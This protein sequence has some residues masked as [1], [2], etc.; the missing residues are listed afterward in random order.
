MRKDYE[1]TLQV[2]RIDGLLPADDDGKVNLVPVG[3][4][5]AS[6][7]VLVPAW[8]NGPSPG[9]GQ[10]RLDLFLGSKRVYQQELEQ[11]FGAQLRCEVPAAEFIHGVHELRY[12]VY[13]YVRDETENSQT[14]PLTVDRI[15]PAANGLGELVFPAQVLSGGVTDAWLQSHGDALSATFPSYSEQ[16]VSDQVVWYWDIAGQRQWE[17]GRAR[18]DQLSASHTLVFPGELIRERGDGSAQAYYLL[19][20]RAGNESSLAWPVSLRVDAQPVPRVLPAAQVVGA[21]GSG[22]EQTL[23]ATLALRGATVRVPASAVIQPGEHAVLHWGRP[24]EAG[25]RKLDPAIAP[26]DNPIPVEAVAAYLDG[27]AQVSYQVIDAEGQAFDSDALALAVQADFPLRALDCLELRGKDALTLGQ[28]PSAGATL[29]LPAWAMMVAGQTLK[30][31]ITGID[32]ASN[33]SREAVVVAGRA[34]AAAEV[35]GNITVMLPLAALSGFK[36]QAQADIQG[37]VSFNGSNEWP[38][39]KAFGKL[40]PKLVP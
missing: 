33:Q 26:G 25:Y 38:R 1:P 18:L 24:G 3:L 14:L 34:V 29:Y 5:A 32:A 27:Q 13:V 16:E 4:L 31:S 19:R 22:A 35:G 36:P 15:A 12:D 20:D 7:A 23:K 17:A 11:P 10:Q 40:T 8:S 30:V 21:T 28:L 37:W 39:A 6:V 9:I 2:P